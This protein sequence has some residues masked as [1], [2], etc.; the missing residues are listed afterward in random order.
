MWANT[1]T[2]VRLLLTFWLVALL[3][4]GTA[5]TLAISFWLTIVI[6]WMDGLD[7]YVARKL[8]E[9][10]TFGAVWDI[11]VDRVVEQIY[12]VAF[13]VLG[14]V[15]LWIPLVVITRG[16]L[17]DGFRAMALKEGFTAFGEN[18]LMQSPIGVLLVSSRFSRWSYAVTKALAF[19]LLIGEQW[20]ALASVVWPGWVHVLTTASVYGAVAF[21]VVRGLPVLFEARRF[22]K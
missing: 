16:V 11:L 9:A 15:P 13:A 18:T 7:G 21:C 2:L 3:L 22:I 6:I 12:W 4:T 5:T 19:A 1:I 14:W 8:D 10:S 20:A 17:V